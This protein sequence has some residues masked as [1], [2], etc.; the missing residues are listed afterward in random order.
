MAWEIVFLLVFAGFVWLL[1][2]DIDPY[3]PPLP[4]SANPRREIGIVLLL[5]GMAL[6]VNAVRLLIINPWF[7]KAAIQPAL[8]EFVNLL[9]ITLPFLA[10]PLYLSL[11][12]DGYTVADVGLTWKNRSTNVTIFA[13]AFGTISGAVAFWTG[14]TVVGVEALSAGA[15]LL[16]VF[17]NAF[18][19]EFF[20]RGVIQNRLERVFGQRMAILSAG[21]LFASTH[22]LLD[23]L[24]LAEE[25]GLAAVL[26]ALL[27]QTLGGMLLG[28]IFVKTRTLWPGVV[29]HYLV[30]WIPSILNLLLAGNEKL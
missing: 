7:M 28:L 10:L 14:E 8:G 11:K 19:E 26:V 15:L 1:D 16:L 27:M 5:W 9:L 22:V 2:R 3:P 30:N 13:L 18:L 12:I 20:Y 24:V 21:F 4:K 25:G 29:C 17:N 6:G 23:F